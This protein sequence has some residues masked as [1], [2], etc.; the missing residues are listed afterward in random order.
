VGRHVI[1]LGHLVLLLPVNQLSDVYLAEKQQVFALI[2]NGLE[3]SIYALEVS[4]LN[5]TPPM[6]LFITLNIF[7]IYMDEHLRK[8]DHCGKLKSF[9]LIITFRMEHNQAQILKVV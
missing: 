1:I 9:Q 6:R 8:V 3:P 2:R 4:N 7:I 5:I